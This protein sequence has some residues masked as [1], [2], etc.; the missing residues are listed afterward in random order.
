MHKRRKILFYVIDE[1][2]T[3]CYIADDLGKDIVLKDGW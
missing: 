1:I 2:K 3:K